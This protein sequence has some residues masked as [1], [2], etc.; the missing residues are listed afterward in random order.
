MPSPKEQFMAAMR[1]LERDLLPMEAD[2]PDL[3]ERSPDAGIETE[4]EGKRY[5]EL[6]RLKALRISEA[7]RGRTR[8]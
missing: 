7:L 6:R 5:G 3:V 4:A 1:G 2:R 8:D